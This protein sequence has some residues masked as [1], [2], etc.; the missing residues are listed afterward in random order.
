M[1]GLVWTPVQPVSR[2]R[3]GGRVVSILRAKTRKSRHLTTLAA[4]EERLKGLVNSAQSILR[5]LT[6]HRANIRPNRFDFSK[7]IP[8]RYIADTFAMW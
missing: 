3:I 1:H 5:H 6:M 7:L 8:L 4:E 2:L